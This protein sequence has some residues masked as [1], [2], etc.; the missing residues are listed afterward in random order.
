MG[1]FDFFSNKKET[2]F[3]PIPKSK[4]LWMAGNK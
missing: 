2:E 1:L 4:S 3:Q